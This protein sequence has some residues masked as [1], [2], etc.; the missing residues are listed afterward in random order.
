MKVLLIVSLVD[1]LSGFSLLIVVNIVSYI[2]L[3]YLWGECIWYVFNCVKELGYIFDL[4]MGNGGD[5]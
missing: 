3:I 2:V 4:F 5:W 1:L